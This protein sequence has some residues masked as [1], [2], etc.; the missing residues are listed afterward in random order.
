MI[1]QGVGIKVEE[2]TK[3]PRQK[4]QHEQSQGG[5]ETGHEVCAWRELG[6]LEFV[7]R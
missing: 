3:V 1:S 5:Q 7:L 2:T 6:V 4:E